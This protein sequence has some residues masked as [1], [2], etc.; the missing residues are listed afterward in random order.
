MT[1]TF[2]A[3]Y[4]EK[5]G[6]DAV[7]TENAALGFDAYL[8]ALKGIEESGGGSNGVLMKEKM[9]QIKNLE[10]ATGIITI[11]TDGDPIKNVIIERYIDEAVIPVYTVEPEGVNTDEGTN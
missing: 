11:G 8:L 10:G 9:S 7:P 3:A 4:R 5:F 6:A 1:E 2:N